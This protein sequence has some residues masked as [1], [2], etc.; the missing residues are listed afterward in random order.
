MWTDV[1]YG[2]RSLAKTPGITLIAILT[3]ALGIGA[4]TAVFSVI[5]SV[6][7][8]PIPY[9]ESDKLLMVWGTKLDR[10]WNQVSLSEPNFWDLKD[11][12]RSFAN[13]AAIRTGSA[14][15][16]GTHYPERLRTARVSAEF[17]E[18]LGVT[19]T[20][21]RGF[22]PEEDDPGQ[23]VQ[24][25]LLAHRTWRARFGSDPRIVG[26][27]LTLDN[28][29]VTVVGVLPADSYWLDRAEVFLP[30]VRSPD[31]SRANNVHQMIGRLKPGVTRETA[32]ADV[33]AVAARLEQLY[34][35]VNDGMGIR[36]VPSEEWRATSETRLT[37]VIL[38]AAVVFLLLIACVNVAN[39]LLARA[40]GRQREMAVCHALGAGRGRIARRI[41]TES[42]LL[43]VIG[44]IVGV[45]L[46]IWGVAL[47]KA[48]DAG[49]IPRVQDV[50]V[51]GWVL[52]FTLLAALIVGTL[53]GLFPAITM[54]F[55]NVV[56]AL[57]EG[58]RGVSGNRGQNRVRRL[59]V[60]TEVALSLML[61]VGAGLMVRSFQLVQR[62]ELG[63]QSE[64]RLVFRVNLPDAY[65]QRDA[66]RAFLTRFLNR[67]ETVPQVTSAAAVHI[68]P[69][70]SGT[71]NTGIVP[72]GGQSDPRAV[73]LAD[74]RLVTP[75]YFR[76]MG[77]PLLRGRAF[78]EQDEL[79]RRMVI[80][81]QGLAEQ[82][83]PGEDP[84]G[85][86]AFFDEQEWTVVGVVGNLRE[87]GLEQDP[88][89]AVYHPYYGSGWS[90]VNLIVHTAGDPGAV[91]P[92]VRSILA[93]LDRSLPASDV[94][95]LDDLAAGSVAARRFNTLLL[96]IFSVIAFILA[97]AGIYGVLA[98]TVARRT[99][100]IGVRV[101]LGASA[102]AVLTQT[103]VEGIRPA[104]VGAAVG[105]V[106]AF[107]LARFMSA[108]LFGIEPTDPITYV[109]VA[110]LLC[111]A[112]VVSCLVPARR[113]A[114]ID[115]VAA[116]REE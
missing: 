101:A 36:F 85:R 80:I 109:A 104:V 12:N 93:E 103:V 47:L 112:A 107:G 74:W 35:N 59:L 60:G 2:S 17:F 37:L 81:S 23:E 42:L 11:L 14:N 105:L 77:I 5:Y 38:M 27:T 67:L 64:N 108:I 32:L 100:E 110:F 94:T 97:L 20:H 116:L 52:G 34:P 76:A 115:P 19:P 61:L 68:M 72:E 113:A 3:L 31:E 30:L 92:S 96:S 102:G 46:A 84:I 29:L 10:G 4:N 89:L 99:S 106:G 49:G 86:R 21:G 39:L 15:L 83:W 22:L 40:T 66:M 57:R 54:P 26:K 95:T 18:V 65:R 111:A 7:F 41:L 1:R 73:V 24:T 51:N 53:A 87:R 91:V 48:Y 58:A 13:V 28:R 82:L 69:L 98:Y 71:T 25:A 63:F 79:Q 78:R 16:T 8:A 50:T 44:A 9:P 114:R 90:P 75:D 33:N 70:A 55:N 45:L 88:T 56:S 62:V 6:L 43:S